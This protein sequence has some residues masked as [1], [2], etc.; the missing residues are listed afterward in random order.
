VLKRSRASPPAW[1]ML[2]PCFTP[3]PCLGG[4][5]LPCP[6]RAQG[7]GST[8]E[9][10]VKQTGWCENRRADQCQVLALLRRNWPE[11]RR[12][13][14]VQELLVL[15]LER[16][17]QTSSMP[18]NAGASVRAT[19]I[20]LY[21][22]RRHSFTPAKGD[23]QSLAADQNP[24]TMNCANWAGCQQAVPT[25]GRI[26]SRDALAPQLQALTA[27]PRRSRCLCGSPSVGGPGD[28]PGLGRRAF[29]RAWAAR[30][31]ISKP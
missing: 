19:P 22:S 12:Y 27:P 9:A 21:E 6:G 8:V 7:P 17:P 26:E 18:V 23:R 29:C 14:L 11:L 13:L 24:A 3:S 15:S 31:G 2:A 16:M 25:A 20:Q 30:L 28:R 1:P 4:G 5:R 10:L